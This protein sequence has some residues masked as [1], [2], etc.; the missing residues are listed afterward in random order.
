M[1]DNTP[2]YGSPANRD[3]YG[4]VI[5]YGRYAQCLTRNVEDIPAA[6]CRTLRQEN[7]NLIRV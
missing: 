7:L 4:Q 6:T 2:Q 3:E 1:T 5:S